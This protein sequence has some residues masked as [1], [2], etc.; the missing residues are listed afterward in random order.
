MTKSSSFNILAAILILLGIILLLEN[1]GIVDGA[2]LIWPVLPL[3]LGMGFTMLYFR[4]RKDLVLL[5]LGTFIGL[6]SLFAF[7]LN[8]TS[9]ALLAYLWP[10]FMIILGLT[11]LA[12]WLESWK[13]VLLYLSVF[14]MALGISF[15]LIF[16]ISTI[17]W[18]ITLI[19]AGGS[20]IIISIFERNIPERAMHGRKK[21]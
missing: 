11:F 12:C 8:F 15:I 21:K 3:I 10:G 16:A 6:V 2:W 18:P 9:W 17:L 13:R 1:F 14:L 19:L 4:T 5:G 7:Y 20:F